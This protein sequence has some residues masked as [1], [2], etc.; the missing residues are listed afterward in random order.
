MNFCL[1]LQKAMQSSSSSSVNSHP[2]SLRP[3]LFACSSNLQNK[4]FGGHRRG[5]TIVSSEGIMFPLVVILMWLLEH[6]EAGTR[7]FRACNVLSRQCLHC[8][9]DAHGC[10]KLYD[11]RMHHAS[12][13]SF[14]GLHLHDF[15]HSILRGFNRIYDVI[16]VQCIL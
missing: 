2:R 7:Y 14:H 10:D 9:Q 13:Q 1:H 12:L 4:C 15:A 16:V 8:V 6:H 3:L 5:D 11:S